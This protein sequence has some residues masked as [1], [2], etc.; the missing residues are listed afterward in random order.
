VKVGFL[1]VDIFE[2]PVFSYMQLN[3]C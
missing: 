2:L 3:V 1:T